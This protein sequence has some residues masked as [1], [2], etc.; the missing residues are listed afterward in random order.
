M[1]DICALIVRFEPS[2]DALIR[3]TVGKFERI[4]IKKRTWQDG[5]TVVIFL[6]LNRPDTDDEGTTTSFRY[7]L[8]AM[9][10]ELEADGASVETR[11]KVAS[12]P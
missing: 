4:I 7:S 8:N 1:S 12:V 9:V 5:N 11:E 3:G 2:L 6:I 10:S